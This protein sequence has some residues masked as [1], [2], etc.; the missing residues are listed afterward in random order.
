MRF[1][2]RQF[3]PAVLAA[4]L[5]LAFSPLVPTARADYADAENTWPAEVVEKVLTMAGGDQ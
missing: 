4:V 2:K 3:V 5:L 1:L